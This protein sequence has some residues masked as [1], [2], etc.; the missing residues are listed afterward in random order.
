MQMS[1][2]TL[3]K[4]D[5][6]VIVSKAVLP[7]ERSQYN[8]YPLLKRCQS[9][10][11]PYVIQVYRSI[12]LCMTNTVLSILFL[13]LAICQSPLFASN[14]ENKLVNLRLSTDTFTCLQHEVVI[15]HRDSNYHS[16]VDEKKQ[17]SIHF[18]HKDNWRQPF[19][20]DRTGKFVL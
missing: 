8:N 5:D 12:L 6:V 1:F 3:G 14:F 18:W 11:S 9:S 20:R 15:S 7:Y 16:I 17:T 19:C 10:Y 2:G 4:Y 13:S